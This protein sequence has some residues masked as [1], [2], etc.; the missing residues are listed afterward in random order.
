VRIL[1]FIV[2]FI[3][4]LSEYPHECAAILW[5]IVRVYVRFLIHVFVSSLWMPLSVFGYIVTDCPCRGSS[6]D[7]YFSLCFYRSQYPRILLLI[8]RVY[9]RHFTCVS[10]SLFVFEYVHQCPNLSSFILDV[11]VHFLTRV[12]VSLFLWLFMSVFGYIVADCTYIG[13]PV[14]PRVCLSLYTSVFVSVRVY[15]R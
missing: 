4:S 5:L 15:Y 2:I 11:Y 13:T 7:P 14:I 3:P 8:L 9:V 10:L 6:L 1:L 12:S